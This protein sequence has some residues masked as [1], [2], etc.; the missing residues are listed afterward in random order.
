MEEIIKTLTCVLTFYVL[1]CGAQSD[2]DKDIPSFTTKARTID[3]WLFSDD[4]FPGHTIPQN[5]AH[6]DAVRMFS[7]LVDDHDLFT[8]AYNRY[9]VS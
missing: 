7:K 6:K 3:E 8:E 4:L 5:V 1:V 2:F 9:R